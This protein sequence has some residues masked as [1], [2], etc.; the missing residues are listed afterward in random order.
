MKIV[1]SKQTTP[2]L[3]YLAAAIGLPLLLLS[4]A[5]ALSTVGNSSNFRI[6]DTLPDN[7]EFSMG[8]EISRRILL[9]PPKH[10]NPL[11]GPKPFCQRKVYGSCLPNPKFYDR[12]KRTCDYNTCKKAP[13]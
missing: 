3:L 6:S 10:A 11:A 13:S 7:E 2:S 4:V 8:S 5:D 12:T 1:N 9:N